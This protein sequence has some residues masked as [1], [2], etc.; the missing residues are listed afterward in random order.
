ME[1]TTVLSMRSLT[2][3]PTRSLRRPRVASFV[4]IVVIVRLPEIGSS[5][6]RLRA[7]RAFL[8]PEDRE[9]AR[10]LAPSAADLEGIVELLHRIAEAQVEELLAQ[11]GH[12][13]L[14]LVH[15]HV[16]HARWLRLRH[17]QLPPSSWRSTKRVRI[18]SFEAP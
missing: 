18:G 5:G 13:G 16:A 15:A 10:H 12:A 11:L 2:T 17:D 3:L 1:T 4:S 9:Q 7:G 6:S 8:F 14:D